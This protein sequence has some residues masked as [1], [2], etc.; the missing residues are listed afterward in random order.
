MAL[1]LYLKCAAC[2]LGIFKAPINV[3]SIHDLLILRMVVEIHPLNARVNSAQVT[4]AD[5]YQQFGDH[6]GNRKV[7]QYKL[8]AYH[9]MVMA[10]RYDYE[11]LT[12]K[13]SI[14]FTV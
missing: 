3:H 8:R 13:P 5:R 9:L 12:T 4:F 7:N 1:Y 11:S 6:F 10:K 14:H 2:A